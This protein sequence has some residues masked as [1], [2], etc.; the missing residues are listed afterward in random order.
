MRKQGGHAHGDSSI[1]SSSPCTYASYSGLR[2]SAAA[3]AA[4][5]ISVRDIRGKRGMRMARITGSCPCA[6]THAVLA[7]A[8]LA[9]VIRGRA[10]ASGAHITAFTELRAIF[11][12]M[13]FSIACS[14]DRASTRR[15]VHPP[16]TYAP[17]PAHQE[18]LPKKSSPASSIAPA[19]SVYCSISVA[20]RCWQRA[21]NS[22]RCCCSF[23]SCRSLHACIRN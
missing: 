7:C 10:P 6:T 2:G 11:N 8:D 20:E 4:L 13:A 16:C 15:V 21:T 9:A 23:S 1:R 17:S 3:L 18:K 5:S 22:H 14:R 12:A 19:W